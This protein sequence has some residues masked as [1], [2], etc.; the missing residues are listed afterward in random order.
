MKFGSEHCSMH[1]TIKIILLFGFF[2]AIATGQDFPPAITTIEYFFD[3]D[4]GVGSGE[5]VSFTSSD[6]VNILDEIDVSELSLGL[7]RVYVRARDANGNWGIPQSRSFLLQEGGTILPAPA[8]TAIEYF[9]DV[10]EG[11]GSG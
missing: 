10:D 4:E 6:S 11:V 8:I 5:P 1:I 2:T 7:H 9:F 3:V